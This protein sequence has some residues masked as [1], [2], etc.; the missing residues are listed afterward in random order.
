[1]QKKWEGLIAKKADR[2]YKS[3]RA[4]DWLKFKCSKRQEF[5]I[6]GYS[7]PKGE[8]IGF[9]ALLIGYYEK[10]KLKYAGK[11]G[12]GFE[13]DMLKFL[14]RKL[15]SI[16]RKTSPLKEEVKEKNVHWVKPELVGEVGYT[17]WTGDGKLRHPRFLGLR[18]NKNPDK[19]IREDKG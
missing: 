19:V 4:S 15:T 12:T 16:E 2:E 10:D 14:S 5:I 9:G 17:E 3:G 7:D 8:R 13:D 18:R 1:M 11:V 6:I